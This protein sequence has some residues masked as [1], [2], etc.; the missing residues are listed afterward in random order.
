MSTFLKIKIR[1]KFLEQNMIKL[2]H[3]SHTPQINDNCLEQR[4][5]NGRP[6]PSGGPQ[7]DFA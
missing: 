5:S 4:F 6:R 2:S 3:Q 1:Q 7:N